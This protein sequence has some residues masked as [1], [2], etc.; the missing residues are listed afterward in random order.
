MKKQNKGVPMQAK[1]DSVSRT[2]INFQL[3]NPTH[4]SESRAD[5]WERT[6]KIAPRICAVRSFAKKHSGCI[7]NRDFSDLQNL[8][9]PLPPIEIQQVIAETITERYRES[10]S[11]RAEA[12]HIVVETKA[13]VERLI[14]GEERWGV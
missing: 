8:E 1:I 4:G 14:L 13:K 11:L 10:R 2:Q 12:E 7:R 9:I 6:G 3:P 5:D